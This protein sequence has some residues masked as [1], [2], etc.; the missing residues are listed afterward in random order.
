MHNEK[1][2]N[3]RGSV[4]RVPRPTK[5]GSVQAVQAR[6]V[7]LGTGYTVGIKAQAGRFTQF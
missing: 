7:I 5:G 2:C 4:P 6:T 1:A 3:L